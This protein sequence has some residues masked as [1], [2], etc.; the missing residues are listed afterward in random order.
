MAFEVFSVPVE[1]APNYRQVLL[2]FQ[3]GLE[4]A[5]RSVA[6]MSACRCSS[7]TARTRSPVDAATLLRS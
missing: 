4:V 5:V 7:A 3:P 1:L 2:G 6:S